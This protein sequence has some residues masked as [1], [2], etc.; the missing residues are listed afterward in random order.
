MGSNN[1]TEKEF[2]MVDLGDGRLNQ[3]LVNISQQIL[4]SPQNHINKACGDWRDT[5]AAYRLFQNENVNYQDIIEAHAQMTKERAKQEETILAIQDTTYYNYTHHPKTEGLGVLSKFKGKHKNE[6]L[7][8]GLCMHTT[9]GITTEGLPLG[10]LDQAI[11][12][13]EEPTKAKKE[14]KKKSHNTALPI[15]EKESIR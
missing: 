2:E 9:L 10:L 1:W 11:F 15:E 13:R 12:S 14:L 4:E 3:R 8:L 5:K 7:T 6:I